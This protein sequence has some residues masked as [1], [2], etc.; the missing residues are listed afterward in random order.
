VL[1]QTRAAEFKGWQ[2]WGKNKSSKCKINLRLIHFQLWSQIEVNSLN[3]W[4][5]K[6]VFSVRSD[7]F[8]YRPRAAKA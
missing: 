8:D 1:L 4:F 6:L 3:G 7:H 5:F 2:N